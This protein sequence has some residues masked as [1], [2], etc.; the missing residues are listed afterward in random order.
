MGP[1]PHWNDGNSVSR[2][3]RNWI[4]ALL[5]AVLISVGYFGIPALRSYLLSIGVFLLLDIVTSRIVP[6]KDL[7]GNLSSITFAL[8]FAMLLPYQ[9]PWWIILVG[10]FITIVIGKR[11]FGGLGAYPV[12][13]VLLCFA[14]LLV[15]WPQRMD[16]TAAMV[17]LDWAVPVIEPL[18]LI[19]TQGS[20]AQSVYHLLDLFLGKQVA[21]IGNG[22]GLFLLIGGI[23]LLVI[24]QITW[25]IP[26]SFL[27]GTFGTAWILYQ[28]NPGQFATPLFHIL[29]GSTFLGAFFLATEHTTS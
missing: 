26:A 21:G 23:Y 1:A 9:T 19:K 12:H 7:P 3:Q 13:P 2:M 11:L 24:R 4:L 16:Y 17:S 10:G 5:P 15:S 20:G 8:L 27:L 18:R 29:S 14:M 25:H 22:M 6:S 28:M